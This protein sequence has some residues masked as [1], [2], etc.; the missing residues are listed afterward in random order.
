M[1]LPMAIVIPVILVVAVLPCMAVLAD[2]VHVLLNTGLALCL[3]TTRSD[4][5]ISRAFAGMH[6]ASPLDPTWYPDTDATH[7]MT[8]DPHFLTSTTRYGSNDKVV[9]GNGETLPIAHTGNL[10]SKSGPFI[11]RLSQVLHVPAIRKNLLSIAKFTRDNLVSL[12]FFPW[13]F[14][15]RDLKTS[16]VLF[17]GPC[18]D[19]LYPLKLGLALSTGSTTKHAFVSIFASPSLWHSRLGH[20]SRQVLNVLA[21]SN[22]LGSSF[23]VSTKDFCNHCALAKSHRLA[24]TS[25][26]HYALSPFEL[27]HSDVWMSPILS[28]S[29]FR[30]YVLFTDDYTRYT[31]IYPMLK[32]SEVFLHFTNFITLISNQFS[33]MVKILQSDRGKDYDNLSFRQLCAKKGIH[34]RFSC[35]HT[36][37][38]N[39]LAERKHRHISEMG[40]TLLLAANL[41][42]KFWAEALCTAVYIINRLPTPV[43]KWTSPFHNLFGRV[44]DYM[45]LRTFGCAC[46]PYLG[47]YATNKLQPRSLL[48]VFLGYGDQYK[49]YR[50]L[51]PSTERVYLSRHVKFNEHDFPFHS[52]MASSSVPASDLVFVPIHPVPTL[53]QDNHALSPMFSSLPPVPMPQN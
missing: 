48:C 16:V 40:R 9:V 21:S 1:A 26:E 36:P 35:P 3:C 4:D 14:V 53:L 19:G 49:G 47:D 22:V 44:P 33:K 43:L 31:W 30:Y 25:S 13:G 28:A 7:H 15:V 11:F 8:N 38:Q 45:A 29:G 10:S 5:D 27:I 50:C 46:F 39:G 37:Q 12:S 24:F 2:M 18:E 52:S 51:H 23:I 6:I 20:P 41:P 42:H 32:K 34:H 17:Q